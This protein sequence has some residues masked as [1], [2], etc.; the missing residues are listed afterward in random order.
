MTRNTASVRRFDETVRQAV[1]TDVVITAIGLMADTAPFASQLELNRNG[2][3]RVNPE[4]LQT[5]S[6]FVFAGGDAVTGPSMIVAAVGQGKRAAYYIDRQ[7]SGQ[8]L[9]GVQFD[10]QLPVSDRAK[11]IAQARDHVTPREPVQPKRRTIAERVVSFAEYE[12]DYSAQCNARPTRL[13][14]IIDKP[15]TDQ[16]NAVFARACSLWGGV[17]NPIVILGG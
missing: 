2:T 6:P 16:L 17:F 15:I 3:V 13:A 14:F 7:L 9:E 11:V 5:S 10:E 8:S 12:D 4:T 1:P